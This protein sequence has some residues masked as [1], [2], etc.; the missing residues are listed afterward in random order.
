MSVIF[1]IREEDKIIVAGDKRLSSTEGK[2]I[3]DDGQKVI[4]I[5]DRLAIATAGNV[6]IE[7]AILKDIEKSCDTSIMTTD[8]VIEIIQNFYKRVLE[9][10]CA[11]IYLLPFYCLIAGIGRDGNAHLVNSGKFKEGFGAKDAPMALYHPADTEQNDCNQI[12]AKNY[13][14]HHSDFCERTVQE[15]SAISKMVSP[16]GDKWIYDIKIHKGC[17]YS[18]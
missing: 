10:D 1:G 12:F 18:F 15:I 6:A 13:K 14:L 8:D 17:L 3:S 4:A 5:N 7:K 16:T 11:S 9:N 2:F